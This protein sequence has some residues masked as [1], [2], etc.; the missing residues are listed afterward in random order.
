MTEASVGRPLDDGAAAPQAALVC[1]GDPALL[2]AVKDDD[3]NASIATEAGSSRREG[4]I[5]PDKGEESSRQ[6]QPRQRYRDWKKSKKKGDVQ[7]ADSKDSGRHNRE[8]QQQGGGRGPEG[9][10]RN[11]RMREDV[12]KKWIGGFFMPFTSSWF[13]FHCHCHA[14]QLFSPPC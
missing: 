13:I 10:R 7:G 11:K 12:E 5:C 4:A 8:L 14:R 1:S 6:E 2:C 9:R 3:V